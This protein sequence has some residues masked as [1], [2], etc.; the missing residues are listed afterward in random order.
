MVKLICR[1]FN[2]FL[3]KDK[4]AVLER[5]KTI[6]NQEYPFMCNNLGRF[7]DEGFITEKERERLIKD[8]W[9]DRLINKLSPQAVYAIKLQ[10]EKT[11]HL[12]CWYETMD[13]DSRIR[14][15]NRTIGR[16]ESKGITR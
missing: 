9:A 4:I 6:T 7:V 5:L 16:L 3:T 1:L 8:L 2:I 12:G 10:G 15:I 11:P 14:N 13:V